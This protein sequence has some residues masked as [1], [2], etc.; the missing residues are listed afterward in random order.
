MNAR[1][2][3]PRGPRAA[4]EA[5]LEVNTS[6]INR[7][8][9]VI[10]VTEDYDYEDLAATKWLRERYGMEVRCV[11][12]TMATDSQG[13]EYFSCTDLSERSLPTYGTLRFEGGKQ[14]KAETHIGGRRIQERVTKYK[15][16]HLRIGTGD[17]FVEGELLDMS[18]GG[19]GLKTAVAL[20]PDSDVTVS[21]DLH[22]EGSGLQI[23]GRARVAHCLSVDGNAFNIGLSFQEVKYERLS[24]P[25]DHLTVISTN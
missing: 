10:L 9:E 1:A 17:R 7:Q 20:D 8:Q 5:F 12:S 13:N 15:A 23:R 18:D 22:G 2:G 16:E 25:D 21:A 19:L 14:A 24:S 4:L 6:E 3:V 11:R